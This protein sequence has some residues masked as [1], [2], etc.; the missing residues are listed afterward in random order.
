MNQP[1]LIAHA[2]WGT[3]PRKRWQAVASRTAD[4]RYHVTA[5]E[6]VGDTAT[7]LDRLRQ[8]A[9]PGGSILLGL[10]LPLGVPLAWAQR[11]GVADFAALLPQLGRDDW[12]D[13]YRPA[14]RP[15]EIS[16]HRPFYPYRPGGTRHQHL[17]DG[18]GLNN[19]DE[20]YRVCDRGH[21]GRGRAAPLF[22]T[23]GAKAVGKAAITAWRDVL[24]PALRERKDVVL[25]PFAGTLDE[26]LQDGL[27]V[28][29]E[30]YPAEFYSHFALS[31]PPGPDGKRGKRV[32][33]SRAA[34][35]PALLDWVAANPVSLDAGL[36]D[37]LLDGFGPEKA[38]EDP[39]D[40]TVGL[41]GMLNVVLGGRPSLE[42][43]DDDIR[44]IEGWI[45]GQLP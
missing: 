43:A 18:L 27:I 15:D 33:A 30:T 37:L 9:D 29:A 45:L 40:A 5:A 36:R 16:L 41:L 11:A 38:G 25:W 22:W 35:A 31:F 19:K 24:G 13:L 17:L 20:L 28:V 10:D 14:V 2:D 1:S 6:P 4:G 42:P 34:T 7:W 39:F 21:A 3:N 8:R 32:Q 12:V 23:L 26:L 44:Q